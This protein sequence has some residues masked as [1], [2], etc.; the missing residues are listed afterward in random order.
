[1]S[2][3]LMQTVKRDVATNIPVLDLI[4]LGGIWH[5]VTIFLDA[6]K[7]SKFTVFNTLML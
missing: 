6:N 4:F 1:M 7:T 2:H 3:V 5:V